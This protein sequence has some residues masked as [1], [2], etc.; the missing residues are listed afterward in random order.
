MRTTHIARTL[1]AAAAAATVFAGACVQ[2]HPENPALDAFPPG[3]SGAT[4]VTYYDVHGRTAQELVGE[5]RRLGPKTTAGSFFG[6]TQ[7]PMK[8]TWRTKSNGTNCTLTSVQ[9][10]MRSDITLPRWTPPADAPQTLVDQWKQFLDALALHE[11]GHKDISA[12]SARDIQR[13]LESLNTFCSSLSNDAKRLTDA[14][15]LRSRQEQERYDAETRHGA[16]QGAVF[17]PRPV[18][19][20][21][22]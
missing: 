8:W 20:P 15:V 14:I 9:V 22:R 2:K 18:R 19:A 21:P 11:I 7:S 12:R 3:I 17:P 1:A 4:D 5:M 10:S 16:T 6:E 13:G